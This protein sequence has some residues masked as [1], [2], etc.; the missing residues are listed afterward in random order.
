MNTCDL[1]GAD[2]DNAVAKALGYTFGDVGH[3]VIYVYKD[4]RPLV[5]L[6]CFTPSTNGY[7]LIEEFGIATRKHSNGKWYAM[8]QQDAGDTT[9]MHWTPMTY[10]NAGCPSHNHKGP[11]PC[12]WVGRTVLE[13]AMRCLVGWH[14]GEDIEL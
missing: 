12:Y 4:G 3:C 10:R 5:P 2:L 7:H 6:S 13:A 9:R 1:E 14:L 8:M 11:R